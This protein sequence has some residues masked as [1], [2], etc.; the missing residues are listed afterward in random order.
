MQ[1]SATTYEV[2]LVND[3]CPKGS[4]EVIKNLCEK[5]SNIKGINLARNFGQPYAQLAGLDLAKGN[6]IAFMDCDLQ[7][8]PESL[9]DLLK[10]CKSGNDV[11]IAKSKSPRDE[12]AL[13]EL[14]S[15]LFY[16]V[17][18]YLNDQKDFNFNASYILINKR[19]ADAFRSMKENQRMFLSLLQY[20]GFSYA[21]VS[22]Q[23]GVRKEG[24]TSYSLRQRLSLALSGIVNS[25]TKLLKIGIII[26]VLSASFSFIFGLYVI[27]QKLLYQAYVDGWVSTILATFFVG[28]VIMVLIGI[29]GLY[30][31]VVF[32]EVK[33]RP[34]YFI[35]ESL[36]I[37][38]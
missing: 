5:N 32:W 35:A 27:W 38:T 26:G 31:E 36:N 7:D 10:S 14:S 16:R 20:I 19:V 11:S 8:R 17:F 37:E 22:V 9:N 4:W 15:K 23:H 24:K 3:A 29:M 2:L 12:N 34:S 21:F 25:S 18:S 6:F 13:R 30:L 33:R 1:S 28:G